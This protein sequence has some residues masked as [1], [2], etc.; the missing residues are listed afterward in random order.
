MD[1]TEEEEE[2]V[3]S[4]DDNNISVDCP[5][6]M[7]ANGS[8]VDQW[9]DDYFLIHYPVN[10][11]THER[12]DSIIHDLIHHLLKIGEQEVEGKT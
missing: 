2:I 4:D 6:G 5:G 10:D 11:C 1:S 8:L 9:I 7:F 3:S 12:A